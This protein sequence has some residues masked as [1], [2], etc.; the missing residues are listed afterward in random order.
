MKQT[1][2]LFNVWSNINR[3]ENGKVE[4]SRISPLVKLLNYPVIGERMEGTSAIGIDP[5]NVHHFGYP[6]L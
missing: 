5:Q 3:S 6:L 2:K 4:S 1:M